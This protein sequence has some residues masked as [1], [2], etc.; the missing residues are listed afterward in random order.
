ML[1]RDRHALIEGARR[2]YHARSKELK[3][4]TDLLERWGNQRTEYA[5]GLFERRLFGRRDRRR[6]AS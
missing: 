2:A 5:I 1:Q 4:F 6:A 3:S